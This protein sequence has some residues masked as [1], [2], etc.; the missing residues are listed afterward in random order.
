MRPVRPPRRG[1]R[2]WLA[3][4]ALWS[5][6]AFAAAVPA[7]TGAQAAHVAVHHA[8]LRWLPGD[9]PLAGYFEL[10]NTGQRPRRLVGASSPAFA[11]VMLHRST[12]AGGTEHMVHVSSVDIAPGKT[13]RFAP[14][15][16]HLMLMKRRHGLKVGDRVPVTLHF[17][18]GRGLT[19][20]FAVRGAGTQ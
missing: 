2:L 9:L 16:Y 15:G 17:A 12:H 10:S 19:V 7:G 4:L 3:A 6:V 14:G 13:L 18:N 11:R 1:A 8:R 20:H 5:G